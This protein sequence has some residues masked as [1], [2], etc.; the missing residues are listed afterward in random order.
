MDKINIYLQSKVQK[1]VPMCN[2][3]PNY[4]YIKDNISCQLDK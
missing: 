3:S 2:L 4:I 1:K